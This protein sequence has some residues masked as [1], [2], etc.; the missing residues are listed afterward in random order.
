MKRDS[1]PNFLTF[2]YRKE[3]HSGLGEGAKR[4]RKMNTCCRARRSRN[5]HGICPAGYSP[6][7]WRLW[8]WTGTR[9]A[10]CV[11]GGTNPKTEGGVGMPD[12]NSA[13]SSRVPAGARPRWSQ[14]MANETI[15]VTQRGEETVKE[16]PQ[17]RIWWEFHLTTPFE[18]LAGNWKS[19]IYSS[20][21][22][23]QW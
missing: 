14:E 4:A 23:Q 16:S 20:T 18:N 22:L 17:K 8:V 2:L 1:N 15:S 11:W 13:V 5:S 10:C 3:K 19:Q 21:K 9:K 6:G 12:D 7:P